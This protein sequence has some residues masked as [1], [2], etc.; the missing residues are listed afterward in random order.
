MHKYKLERQLVALPDETVAAPAWQT[1]NGDLDDE[2][3]SWVDTNLEVRTLLTAQYAHGATGSFFPA[4]LVCAFE[5]VACMHQLTMLLITS[6]M[7]AGGKGPRMLFRWG[8]T[9]TA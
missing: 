6:W 9:G 2:D 3:V 4:A 8:H 5:A 7:C 1:A